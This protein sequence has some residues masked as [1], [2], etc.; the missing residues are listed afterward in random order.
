MVSLFNYLFIYI[1]RIKQSSN[2][3]IYPFVEI[4]WNGPV[5]MNHVKLKYFHSG[6]A[7]PASRQMSINLVIS[8]SPG[9]GP[10]WG[11]KYLWMRGKYGDSY[12]V[13]IDFHVNI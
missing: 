1:F 9:V 8:P 10:Q 7:L 11:S 13:A 6:E 5:T 4:K 2:I 12:Y 3:S